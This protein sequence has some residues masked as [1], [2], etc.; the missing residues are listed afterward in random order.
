MQAFEEQ[1]YNKP[2]DVKLWR[3]ILR[4]AKPYHKHLIGVGVTMMLCTLADIWFPLL[5]REAIDGFVARGSVEGLTWFIVRYSAVILFQ[6]VAVLI[7][8]F[9]G[10]RAEVG[11]CHYIRNIGFKRLQELPPAYYDKM[12]MGYIIARMTSDIARLGDT[13]GWG[14]LDI[15][16]GACYTLFS[17]LAMALINWRLSLAVMG[18]MPLLAVITVYFQRRILKSYRRVR[19]TNSQITGAINEG[20]MGAGTTKTL[21]TEEKNYAEFSRL[22]RTMK[23]ESIRAA[24]LSALFLPTVTSLGAIATAYILYRGGHEVVVGALSFGTLSMFITFSVQVFEPIHQLARIFADIQSAQSAAER[25]MELLSTEPAIV[26]RESV[27]SVYGDNFHPNTDQW[28]E[29]RGDIEFQNV[30]FSYDGG[31]EVLNDF[32]LTVR[33]GET[34]ALVGETG[35]GKS[36]IVNLLCRFYEPTSGKILIDGVDYRER[37]Q[38][39]IEANLGYVLQQPHLFSGTIAENIR[40]GKLDA[41]DEEVIAAAKSVSADGFIEAFEDGYDTQ[42]GEGGARLST[43]QKQL[44]SFARALIGKPKLFVLDEATS[45]VDAQTEQII[46]RALKTALTG[47]TGFVIAHRLSTIRSADRILVVRE[48]RVTE[49]GTHAQLMKL[50]GYYYE[51]YAN[52]FREERAQALLSDC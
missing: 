37:S 2:L 30:S 29:M 41:S 13:I 51:L 10:G 32:S 7:F 20:I 3:D 12:P 1:D 46:Q 33:A 28:P 43:G 19:K 24:S 25:V 40:Y 39:W 18:V 21:V 45:S 16:W 47:R 50:R 6:T 17:F 8:C 15:A 42:V 48:G 44:I 36:T 27:V 34:I 52:Q 38:L 31:G 9:L 23:R 14:L 26:D 5:T 11:I 22:T 35:S 4:Y 49:Q